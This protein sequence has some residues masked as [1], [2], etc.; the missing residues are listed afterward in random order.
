MA[1]QERCTRCGGQVFPAA[2][3]CPWCGMALAP[4]EHTTDSEAQPREGS[5][6]N[7]WEWNNKGVALS[8]LG[9]YQEAIECYDNALEIDPRHVNAWDNKG[10]NLNSVGRYQEAIVCYDKALEIDPRFVRAW[11]GKGVSLHHLGRYE[12]ALE[13]YNEALEIDPSNALAQ[14]GKRMALAKRR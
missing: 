11:V 8:R 1:D 9:R 14:K 10:L 4:E 7:A 12:E 13:C 3:F 5:K 2:R 6:P